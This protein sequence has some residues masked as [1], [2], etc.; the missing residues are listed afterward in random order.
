VLNIGDGLIL[1]ICPNEDNPICRYKLS[2]GW[3][4]K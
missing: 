2:G 1:C 3:P 4:D